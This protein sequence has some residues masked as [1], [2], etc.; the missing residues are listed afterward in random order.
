LR[1]IAKLEKQIVSLEASLDPQTTETQTKIKLAEQ[2][3]FCT[4]LALELASVRGKLDKKQ[5]ERQQQQQNEKIIIDNDDDHEALS[6][7]A[8]LAAHASGFG[9]G[10]N[11]RD[12]LF[13]VCS[14]IIFSCVL[15]GIKSSR[16]G[17]TIDLKWIGELMK[18]YTVGIM[19]SK[20]N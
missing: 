13:G 7:I 11:S 5:K 19:Q 17:E 18:S 20:N 4:Q 12:Y 3:G 10:F 8:Q 1:E 16:S 2:E 9:N 6:K 15:V 14:G